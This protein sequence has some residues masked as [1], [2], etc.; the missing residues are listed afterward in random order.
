[1]LLDVDLVVRVVEVELVGAVVALL[2]DRVET[3]KKL[4]HEWR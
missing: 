1:M 4:G 3:E 2:L